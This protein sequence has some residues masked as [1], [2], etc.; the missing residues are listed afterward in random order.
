MKACVSA[1]GMRNASYEKLDEDGVIS[2]GVRVSGSDAII[3][4]T[5]TLPDNDDEVHIYITSH[6]TYL[7]C[8]HTCGHTPLS[9]SIVHVHPHL[10][11]SSPP[12]ILTFHYPHLP[13]SSPPMSSP[14]IILTSHYPHL[15]LSSPP[16]T[17]PSHLLPPSTVGG[18]PQ[19]VLQE[20]CQHIHEVQ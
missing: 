11:L 9:L 16:I 15:P 20:R 14:P 18:S 2:P 7:S 1:A 6:H 4:K 10:P 12:I 13:L 19:E 17:L 5:I 8:C 3:G